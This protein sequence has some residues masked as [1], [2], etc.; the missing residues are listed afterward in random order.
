MT[1]GLLHGSDQLADLTEARDSG[2]TWVA[3]ANDRDRVD[4]IPRWITSHSTPLPT[5]SPIS[6]HR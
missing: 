2:A 3:R 1:H 6:G 5:R 4:R